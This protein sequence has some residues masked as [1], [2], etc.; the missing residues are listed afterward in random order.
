MGNP[1]SIYRFSY[2][3]YSD[4]TVLL[5]NCQK[6]IIQHPYW[7]EMN[8]CMLR[9]KLQYYTFLCI[10]RLYINSMQGSEIFING[11]LIIWPSFCIN[12]LKTMQFFPHDQLQFFFPLHS[13][14][15]TSW[16]CVFFPLS[17][18]GTVTVKESIFL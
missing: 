9:L 2:H 15:C 5:I 8:M 4:S 11:T 6:N 10:W 7:G 3:T 18:P 13:K 12:P 17:L 1:Y 14:P 16:D